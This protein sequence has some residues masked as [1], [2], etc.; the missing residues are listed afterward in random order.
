MAPAGMGA[1]AAAAVLM[2][3]LF[4][5]M[6][7][8]FYAEPPAGS[9][10]PGPVANPNP[11]SPQRFWNDSDL[12]TRLL[13]Y[14]LNLAGEK[15]PSEQLGDLVNIAGELERES[16]AQA[17]KVDNADLMRLAVL[18]EKVVDVGLPARAQ[19]LSPEERQKD[20]PPIVTN[21]RQLEKEAQLAA[22]ETPAAS[23]PLLRFSLAASRGSRL[24]EN[25]MTKPLRMATRVNQPP[26]QQPLVESIVTTGV[27]LAGENDPL[28]RAKVG[29][30]AADNLVRII[31]E[32]SQR[33]SD[34][35]EMERLGSYLGLVLKTAV[36]GNLNKVDTKDADLKRKEESE[37]L[38]QRSTSVLSGWK[39]KIDEAPP[40]QRSGLEQA[41][42][43]ARSALQANTPPRFVKDPK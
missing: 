21:L 37:R 43:A 30:D 15:A 2:I 5:G 28:N 7:Y 41:Y 8:Y 1:M 17:G 11:G 33:G 12:R 25:P 29:A 32:T 6:L 18:F 26:T 13:A 3:A 9:N 36:N 40:E 35:A 31:M 24:L 42:E 23:D 10:G 34:Q 19:A 22:K 16:L 27:S 38:R 4:G 14:T 39:Q 20:L